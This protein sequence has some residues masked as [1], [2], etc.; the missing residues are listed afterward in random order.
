[1]HHLRE[2]VETCRTDVV[3]IAALIGAVALRSMAPYV[4]K[5]SPALERSRSLH[6]TLK[7]KADIP[8]N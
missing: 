6:V 5:Q 4:L 3:T 8:N 1:M 2:L 7:S